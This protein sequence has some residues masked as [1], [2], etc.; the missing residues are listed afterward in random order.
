MKADTIHIMI[1]ICVHKEINSMCNLLLSLNAKQFNINLLE[2][3]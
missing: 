2:L 1:S 3:Y